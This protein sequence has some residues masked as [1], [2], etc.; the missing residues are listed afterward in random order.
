[1][2]GITEKLIA[3]ESGRVGEILLFCLYE[4]KSNALIRKTTIDGYV[5]WSRDYTYRR[6]RRVIL[7]LV[8][9]GN[10][11]QLQWLNQYFPVEL[12]AHLMPRRLIFYFSL[13]KVLQIELRLQTVHLV[14]LAAVGRK[15]KIW[16]F[17]SMRYPILQSSTGLIKNTH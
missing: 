7:H 3:K 10:I 11:L 16:H 8:P 1:M 6:I 13:L 2:D 14:L 17:T 15:E 4:R 12:F 9:H 5:P